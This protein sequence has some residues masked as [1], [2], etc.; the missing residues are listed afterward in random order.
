MVQET[1]TAKPVF[2]AIHLPRVIEGTLI[3]YAAGSAC[4]WAIRKALLPFPVAFLG[5]IA[6]PMAIRLAIHHIRERNKSRAAAS[7]RKLISPQYP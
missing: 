5:S 1:R 2:V 7:R 6:G 3:D 4:F